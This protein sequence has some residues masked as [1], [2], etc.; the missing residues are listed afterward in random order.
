MQAREKS[1]APDKIFTTKIKSNQKFYRDLSWP[2]FFTAGW[3]VGSLHTFALFFCGFG[4]GSECVGS[5]AIWRSPK[6]IMPVIGSRIKQISEPLKK[7]A[8]YNLH[9]VNIALGT[10]FPGV[11]F[12]QSVGAA[13]AGFVFT[14]EDLSTQKQKPACA[15]A[16]WPQKA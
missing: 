13:L 15:A 14:T 10:V 7:Q 6:Y 16:G 1:K 8:A 9:Y 11:S 5:A 12:C 2:C 3:P 4:H